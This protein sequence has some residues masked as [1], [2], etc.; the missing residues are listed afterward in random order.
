MIDIL[1]Y[2]SYQDDYFI[3]SDISVNIKDPIEKEKNR[4]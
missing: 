4:N 1:F 3:Q 2:H